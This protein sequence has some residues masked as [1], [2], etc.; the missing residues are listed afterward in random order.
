MR[1]MTAVIES[2]PPASTPTASA[3]DT[4]TGCTILAADDDPANLAALTAALRTCGQAIATTRSGL[5]A[6][7][8]AAT[9]RPDIMLL[10]ISMPPGIDGF[11]TIRRLKANPH[12]RDIPVIV[13][14]CRTE[15]DDKVKA[16]SLGAVDY[17][18]KPFRPEEVL[19]R[20]NAHLAIR[21]LQRSLADQNVALDRANRRMMR[22]L[23][24]AGCVQRA[25]LPGSF[26]PPKG[27]QAAW[28]WRPCLEVG[29]DCLDVFR[30]RDQ[31]IGFYLLDVSGHGVAA[32]LLA[33]SV[34]RSLTP[35]QDR[36]SLV[37]E[38]GW[39]PAG[40]IVVRPSEVLRRL[41]TLNP[42]YPDRNPHFFTMAYGLLDCATGRVTLSCA[43]HPPPVVLLH[44]GT[45]RIVGLPSV[46]IG[47]HPDAQF[48]ETEFTLEDGDRL[49]I[50]SDGATEQRN[51]GGI[52]FGA[53]RLIRVC[54]APD[55]ALDIVL[56]RAVEEVAQ[57]AQPERLTDDLSLL[58][59]GRDP[60]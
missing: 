23:Q 17:I 12:L 24:A 35:R 42:M 58:A 41:N 3:W 51:I 55:I 28:E 49:L 9:I 15:T 10:D 29:G 37:I 19:A 56:G 8:M 60:P 34:A 18:S 33:V 43:G 14:S 39:D 59:I 16:I 6:L 38:N 45:H 54:S 40:T 1:S 44:D 36:T 25:L 31:T 7:E 22:D 26:R 4:P 32:A 21:A 20:V 46:P 13:L 11:E 53:Q 52:P 47:I 5:G 48:E 27:V 2:T 50:Y 57:W 30:I